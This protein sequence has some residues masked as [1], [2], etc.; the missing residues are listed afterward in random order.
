MEK[1][2]TFEGE[3]LAIGLHF[4]VQATVFY[5]KYRVSMTKHR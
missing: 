4:R 2:Y 5:K 1:H 3:S